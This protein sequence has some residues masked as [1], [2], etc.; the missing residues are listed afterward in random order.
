MAR[1]CGPALRHA[2]AIWVQKSNGTTGRASA[3]T[4]SMS[5]LL[6]L[7]WKWEKPIATGIHNSELPSGRKLPLWP[8]IDGDGPTVF[9]HACKLGLEGVV[10]KR[11]NSPYRSGRSPDWLKMKNSNA[12]AVKREAEEDWGR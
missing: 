2:P 12:P 9:A 6:R 3:P 5:Q 1:W 11:K 10:S 4:L 8:H 7:K